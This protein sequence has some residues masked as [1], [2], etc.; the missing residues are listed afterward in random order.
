MY[1][2]FFRW[3]ISKGK[4]DKTL[5]NLKKFEKI[6]KTQ[7]PKDVLDDLVVSVRNIIPIIIF[8]SL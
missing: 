6:N 4:M 1:F 7:I 3:S 5:V 2:M 8:L